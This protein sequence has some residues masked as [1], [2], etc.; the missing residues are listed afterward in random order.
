MDHSDC[1]STEATSSKPAAELLLGLG[2]V[3]A[4]ATPSAAAAATA[5]AAVDDDEDGQ[6][7]LLD[8]ALLAGLV[9]WGS[10]GGTALPDEQGLGAAE[11]ADAEQLLSTLRA[12][13]Q[14]NSLSKHKRKN[15]RA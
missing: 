9:L 7:Q 8:D 11:E 10:A 15:P 3:P 14:V 5:S 6:R 13:L 1:S 2:A 4:G 12:N